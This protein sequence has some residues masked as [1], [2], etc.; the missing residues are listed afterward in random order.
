MGSAAFLNEAI[1]QLAEA[2][3]DRKQKE[4][5]ETI[6]YEKRFDELQRVKMYI[7][8]RNVY[9][10]DLNRLP[11]N[12]QSI[13]VAEYDLQRRFVPWFIMQLV[14]GNSSLAHAGS[15]IRSLSFRQTAVI[16]TTPPRAC[17]I[18]TKRKPKS[19]VY[20]FFTGDTGMSN[21][22]DKVIKSS[23]RTI[24][25]RSRAGISSLPALYG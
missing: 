6:S 8:D 14:C 12:W 21:Y 17:S 13:P 1:N 18:G 23:P 25:R 7:A 22:T 19:Q 3:I 4:L 16:G 10:I 11:L 2:Y 20:H 9:G 15:A 5:G 24:S